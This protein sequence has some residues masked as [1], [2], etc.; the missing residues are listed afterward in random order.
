MVLSVA[1]S[2]LVK[3]PTKGEDDDSL[4]PAMNKKKKK[5]KREPGFGK[6]F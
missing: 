4:A 5:S 1:F 2:L 3:D 6:S